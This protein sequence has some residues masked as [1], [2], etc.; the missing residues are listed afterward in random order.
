MGSF[1]CTILVL[2]WKEVSGGG[3]KNGICVTIHG[4]HRF[5]FR[6]SRIAGVHFFKMEY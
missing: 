3:C 6:S 2:F 5:L 1:A 4:M